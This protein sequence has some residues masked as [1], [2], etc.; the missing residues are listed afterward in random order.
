MKNVIII[1]SYANNKERRDILIESIN[2]FKK[3]NLDIILI[4]NFKDDKDVQNS[5]D[6]YLYDADNYLLPKNKSPLNWFADAHETIHLF[7]PGTS[8][9]VY[10]NMCTAIAYA[11]FMN[12]KKFFYSEFDVDFSNED[13]LKINSIFNILDSKK[14]WLCKFNKAVES[15]STISFAGDA[16]FFTE[17]LFR[18]KD[19][20]EWN[21]VQPF[22]TNTESLEYIFPIILK[23][24]KNEIHVEEKTLNEFF[25]LSKI[26]VF[27]SY[28]NVNLAYNNELIEEPIL[29]TITDDGE[30]ELYIDKNLIFK[31]NFK[32]G[33]WLK[34]RIKVNQN[35]TEIKLL[36]NKKMIYNKKINMSNIEEL[37]SKAIRYKL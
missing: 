31:R 15:Y 2:K 11:N 24:I 32:S 34:Q 3:L 22:S 37:K 28:T 21:T 25:T 23:H 27:N 13:L 26:N 9:I 30:Y 17:S 12:Y 18:I 8:Y 6:H 20:S 14:I 35:D 4:S 5:V 19:I 10:K 33:I 16:K 1:N 36:F 7:H 29:F